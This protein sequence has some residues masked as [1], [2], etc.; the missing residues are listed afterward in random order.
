MESWPKAG[1]PCPAAAAAA[2]TWAPGRCEGCAA[3]CSVAG[4][5]SIPT[6][7]SAPGLP[8]T[9]RT[10]HQSSRVGRA[11]SGTG[12]LWGSAG[13][14]WPQRRVP[15]PALTHQLHQHLQRARQGH[16]TTEPLRWENTS[17]TIKANLCPIITLSTRTQH[18]VPHA[19]FPYAPPGTVTPPP[20]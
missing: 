17:E 3:G 18:K 13:Q 10:Q 12:R 16:R 11:G 7:D 15:Q 8:R 2:E 6:Q 5:P 20:P 19:V 14:S 4:T 9:P 1:L